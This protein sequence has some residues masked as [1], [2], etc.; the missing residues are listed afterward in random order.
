MCG[1][2]RL[3]GS[4]VTRD[5]DRKTVLIF[6]NCPKTFEKYIIFAE[7]FVRVKTL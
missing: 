5:N 6:D 1:V 3:V 7:L 2:K 4:N